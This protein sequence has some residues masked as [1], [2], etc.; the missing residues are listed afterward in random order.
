MHPLLKDISLPQ[1]PRILDVCHED[2]HELFTLSDV[3]ISDYSSIVFDYALLNKPLYF[4][5]PDLNDYLK[6]VGCY[7]KKE[8]L[9]IEVSLTMNE[10]IEAM[11]VPY[12]GNIEAFKN[13]FFTYQD[14]KNTKRVVELI[15]DLL[16]TSL[17]EVFK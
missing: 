14:G 4:Y 8:D 17:L 10:L 7:V 3:L 12:K 9:P 5:T 13:K 15:L 2:T 11:Q 1:H 6:D 16:K